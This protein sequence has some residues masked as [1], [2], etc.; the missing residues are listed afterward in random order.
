[1][2][3]SVGSLSAAETY[4][5]NRSPEYRS[6]ARKLLASSLAADRS[7]APRFLAMA[8]ENESMF[9]ASAKQAASVKTLGA[10]PLLVAG[11][12]LPNPI[13]GADGAPFQKYT[14][15]ESRKL[16]AKSS[17]GEFVLFEDS[18]PMVHH[19]APAR[20]IEALRALLKRVRSIES[21]QP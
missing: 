3:L 4:P 8:S 16:A 2:I 10:L 19:D 12:A 6:V 1:M 14:V 20:V 21:K 18:G 5:T 15:D 17:R 11:A 7:R 13:L 9:A